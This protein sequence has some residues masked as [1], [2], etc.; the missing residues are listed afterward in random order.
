MKI[1]TI[2]TLVT[3]SAVSF[4]QATKPGDTTESAESPAPVAAAHSVIERP[5]EVLPGNSSNGIVLLQDDG[6][7]SSDFADSLA[8]ETE[9]GFSAGGVVELIDT[10]AMEEEVLEFD[11][12][13]SQVID[14]VVPTGDA[15]AD[16]VNEVRIAEIE[17]VAPET[18]DMPEIDP[19]AAELRA[20]GAGD[21]GDAGEVLETSE[22]VALVDPGEEEIVEEGGV[23]EMVSQDGASLVS[24][25]DEEEMGGIADRLVDS[26]S[27][28]VTGEESAEEGDA[29]GAMTMGEEEDGFWLRAARLNDVFQYLAR[30]ANM[31]YFHNSDLDAANYVVTG[32]LS[33]GN[34][35]EQMEELGLMYG[36]TI[37]QKGNTVYA[38]T[39]A[40]LAQLP[41]KPFYYQLKYLR[42][43]D[44]EQIRGILQPMMTAGSGSVDFEPKTNTL[45]FIDNE[46]RIENIREVL[47]ELDKPKKQIAIETRIMRIKSASRN[48]IGVDWESVLGDGMTIDGT[49]ALN[50]LFNL[51][52]SDLVNEVI[53][54]TVDSSG[55]A[56]Y[57]IAGT[58]ALSGVA[59][60]TS[61]AVS[62]NSS[63]P[64]SNT[65]LSMDGEVT[66][67]DV[68]SGMAFS[69]GGTAGFSNNRETTRTI[70]ST[71][72]QLVLSPLQMQA[73]IR[74]L[75]SGGLA[76]QESSP[77]LITEDNEAGIISII[78]RI[79]II[80][81][82][83]S[84]TSAGQN[85]TEEVRYSI[86]DNDP[87]MADDP[88]ATREVGVTVSVTPTILPD[89]T[90]RMALRPRSAQI[91][92]FI[93]GR[94][95][96]AYP[97][98]NE[99]T[100]DTIARVPNGYSLLIGG[101]YEEQESDDTSKVPILGDVPGLNFMFKSTDR[102][103]EHT[104]L[105]FVITPKLY[106]PAIIQETDLVN[107]QIHNNHVL[108][109]DHKWPD[110][111]S[112]G[113]NYES[114]LGWSLGNAVNAYPPTPPSSPLHP[115]H[116][117]NLPTW[118][119]N[120]QPAIREGQTMVETVHDT[121]TAPRKKGLLGNL[122]K[123]RD[124]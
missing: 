9:G 92:E 8:T 62:I 78:D 82:T 33:E 34:P 55:R 106:E 117:V 73:T 116:P 1:Y 22:S 31:Q 65:T 7:D 38:M 39:A 24:T 36:I 111:K 61:N 35:I 107:R 119:V 16:S 105:V 101:F 25:I 100:V 30:L 40:Q 11:A 79:P 83:V 57:T 63:V 21:L 50:A 110:R 98:V 109:T 32:H 29:A 67:N 123:K 53:T 90:I 76:Q 46:Q 26:V 122:F 102:M 4:F 86:D 75:N 60:G 69:E 66:G 103:K 97:R 2:A 44:I 3:A 64:E 56:G 120:E 27:E 41:T 10:A 91:V 74:A 59:A 87:T 47:S 43:S 93:Q 23:A 68:F 6:L 80:I 19:V 89:N 104:S 45:I 54:K 99:S 28:A 70:D 42:P 13:D 88:S 20:A 12:A 37:H 72:S 71:E 85:V 18:G 124:R 17:E 77:T 14:T 52:D 5:W 112:P 121:Q 115:D 84:E 96:N 94:S 58:G 51:P 118:D 81:A 108:P 113:S 48:R 114:N 95:G 49:T 15:V